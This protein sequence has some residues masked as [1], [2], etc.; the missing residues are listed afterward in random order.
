MPDLS[1]REMNAL[2]FGIAFVVIFTGWHFGIASS[3]KKNN[4]LKQILNSKQAALEEIVLLEQQF[5]AVSNSKIKTLGNQKK[6]FSLFSFLDSQAQKSG[7]KDNVVYMKPVTKKH[8]NSLYSLI[9]VKVNLKEVHLKELVDFLYLIESSK[10][11]LALTSLSL[12]KAGEKNMKLDAII[13][14]QTVTLNN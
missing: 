12:S 6:G 9:T 3:V 13:E 2:I 5:M 11:N 4:N 14:T 10:N 1:K 7:V 8:D